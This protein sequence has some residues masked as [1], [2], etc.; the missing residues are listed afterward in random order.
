MS[1]ITPASMLPIYDRAIERYPELINIKYARPFCFQLTIRAA[2][3]T[4]TPKEYWQIT[5][6][7]NGEEWEG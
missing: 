1:Y 4:I 7:A 5:R 2:V 6:V 3:P